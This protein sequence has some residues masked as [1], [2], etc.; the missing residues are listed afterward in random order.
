MVI[1][2]IGAAVALALTMMTS[3]GAAEPVRSTADRGHCS[4]ADRTFIQ[5]VK[6]LYSNEDAGY[7]A[8]RQFRGAEVLVPAQPGLTAEWLE[9]VFTSEVAAGQ[10]DLG[11]SKVHVQVLSAGGGFSVR[12]SSDDEKGAAQILRH[13]QQMV[14]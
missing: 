13:T 8:Y 12:L 3:A 14:K 11:T 6:P 5:S 10:C 1:R 7:T 9:R 2:T 4:L